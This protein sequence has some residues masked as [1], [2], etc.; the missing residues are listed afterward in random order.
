VSEFDRDEWFS[1]ERAGRFLGVAGQTVRRWIKD[2][3][4]PASRTPSGRYLIHKDALRDAQ[5]RPVV[6]DA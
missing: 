3:T 2:G 4:L 6:P 5:P 1:P